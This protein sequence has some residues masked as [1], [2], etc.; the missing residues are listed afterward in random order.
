MGGGGGE[1][2]NIHENVSRSIQR[3]DS[4]QVCLEYVLPV[5]S[6]FS[7]FFLVL[8]HFNSNYRGMPGWGRGGT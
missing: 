7:L 4:S 1:I 8:Y 6:L 3:K 2:V 5:C